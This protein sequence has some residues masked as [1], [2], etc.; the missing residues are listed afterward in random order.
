M[1]GGFA[2]LFLLDR[3][4]YGLGGAMVLGPGALQFCFRATNHR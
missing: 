1:F 4:K 2:W 3:A